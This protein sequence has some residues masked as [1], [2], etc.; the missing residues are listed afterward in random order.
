[1]KHN[2]LSLGVL[3]F[4][5]CIL[6][7]CDNNGIKDLNFNVSLQNPKAVYGVGE[8]VIF[9]ISGGPNYLVFFSGEDGHK[10]AN[11]NRT[12]AD[13]EELSLSYKFDLKYVLPRFRNQGMKVWISEDFTGIYDEE[14]INKATWSDMDG[15]FKV[16]AFEN[17]NPGYQHGLENVEVELSEY[18]Y[19]NF[20]LAVEYNLP[21]LE[22]GEG[23]HPDVYFYPKL[24]QMIDGKQVEKKSPKVDFGFNFVRLKS[25]DDSS[26]NPTV[27]ALDDEK[28][29]INGRNG[30]NGTH[31]WAISLP[32]DAAKVNPDEGLS[33]KNMSYDL[34][35]YT[36]IYSEPGEYTVTFVA[37]NAN[38]WNCTEQIKE[39][40]VIVREE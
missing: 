6:A 16:P 29:T 2:S 13:V 39:I 12:V 30:I 14:N 3:S 19:K 15:Q 26:K 34:P 7:A 38:A 11:R 10:Y 23:A 37:R 9:D 36:H 1:M 5:L 28:V 22:A 32:I 20:Y 27:T 17:S 18:K 8:P 35:N 40:K 21:P 24:I 25:N 31:V 4:V 33:I